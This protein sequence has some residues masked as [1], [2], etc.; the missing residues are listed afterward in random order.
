[1]T[2]ATAAAGESLLDLGAWR[3]A[4]NVEVMARILIRDD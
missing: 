4:A 3:Q 1:V 2:N